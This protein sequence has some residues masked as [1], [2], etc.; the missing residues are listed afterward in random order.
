MSEN[1]NQTTPRTGSENS[2]N[3]GHYDSSGRRNN[4]SG[5]RNNRR[6]RPSQPYGAD[7]SAHPTQRE[8]IQFGPSGQQGVQSGKQ[9]NSGNRADQYPQKGSNHRPQRPNQGF[10]GNP[11]GTNTVSENHQ[12]GPNAASGTYQTNMNRTSERT[13]PSADRQGVSAR[14]D[15]VDYQTSLRKQINPNPPTRTER[16]REARTWGRHIRSEETYEDVRKENERL[17]KEI[18]LEI[19]SIHTSKLD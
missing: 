16:P 4:P 5:N 2:G 7:Q 19:A 6:R 13:D 11:S 1:A 9:Q 15:K 14:P 8:P 10:A 18:W 17:E 3:S 12:G